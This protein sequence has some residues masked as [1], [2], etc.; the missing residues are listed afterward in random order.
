[1]GTAARAV[2]GGDVSQAAAALTRRLLPQS[3]LGGEGG[4]VNLAACRDAE[5]IRRHVLSLAH[6]LG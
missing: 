2:V 4:E 1:M 5:E 6:H 3:C